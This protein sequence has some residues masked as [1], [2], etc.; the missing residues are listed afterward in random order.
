MSVAGQ[1]T[2]LTKLHIGLEFNYIED[3]GA[4]QIAKALGNLEHLNDLSINVASKN[5]GYIGYEAIL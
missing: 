1:M 5:F 3:Y 4:K 2:N